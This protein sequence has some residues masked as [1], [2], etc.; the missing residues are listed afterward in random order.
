MSL[1][2]FEVT[3]QGSRQVNHSGRNIS[4]TDKWTATRTL[5]QLVQGSLRENKEQASRGWNRYLLD[6]EVFE[7]IWNII[8][9][10]RIFLSSRRDDQTVWHYSS[11][12]SFELASA[13]ELACQRKPN[14]NL[15]WILIGFGIFEPHQRF[16]LACSY[17]T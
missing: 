15:A 13:Y 1:V 7:E 14:R 8:I 12:D 11:Y 9:V 3:H 6:F 10:I 16:V 4:W 5:R 17:C 2:G